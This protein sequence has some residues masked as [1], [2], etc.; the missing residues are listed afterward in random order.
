MGDVTTQESPLDQRAWTSFGQRII[1]EKLIRD[2]EMYKFNWSDRFIWLIMILVLKCNKKCQ[3]VS[4]QRPPALERPLDKAAALF[5]LSPF[6]HIEQFHFQSEDQGPWFLNQHSMLTSE[7]FAFPTRSAF[8][9]SMVEFGQKTH[10]TL[11]A[12]R[13]LTLFYLQIISTVGLLSTSLTKV[14]ASPEQMET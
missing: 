6:L 5:M 13:C 12:C 9:D 8:T 11:F 4:I 14:L 7:T 1:F 2:L 3:T 10:H